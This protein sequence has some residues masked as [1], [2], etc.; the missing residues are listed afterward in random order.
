MNHFERTSTS[1]RW[2]L[3]KCFA[4]L[5]LMNVNVIFVHLGE[6]LVPYLTSNIE[7]IF[8]INEDQWKGRM[9]VYIITDS[10]KQKDQ[11]RDTFK[12]KEYVKNIKILEPPITPKLE[13]FDKMN[14]LPEGFWRNCLRRFFVLESFMKAENVNCVFHLEND[15]ICYHPFDKILK[16]I[17][18]NYD[19]S[20]MIST[21]DHDERCVPGFNF[22]PDAK[23]LSLITNYA[24]NNLTADLGMNDMRILGLARIQLGPLVLDSFPI[25]PPRTVM[26][27]LKN[28]TPKQLSWMS[29]ARKFEVFE[30]I[31]DAAALGQFI[32]G[33]DP[34]VTPHY[35]IGFINET[36]YVNY[37]KDSRI[38]IENGKPEISFRSNNFKRWYGVVTLHI[39]SKNVAKFLNYLKDKTSLSE[40]AFFSEEVT[41]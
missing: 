15:V 12:D 5:T 25:C 8:T 39:H 9:M 7:F 2:K 13:Q 37:A 28:E 24:L 27:N 6:H 11:I 22:I 30:A 3:K 21:F 14:K 18:S 17:T 35:G 1:S 34:N 32:D 4:E 41:N 31:F 23:S 33:T 20:S 26:R 40:E 29:P 36:C 16:T 10:Q 19:K 38:R